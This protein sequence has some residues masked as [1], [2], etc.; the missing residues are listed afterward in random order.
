MIGYKREGWVTK[1]VKD[2]I[3]R[4]NLSEDHPWLAN[5]SPE[6]GEIDRDNSNIGDNRHHGAKKDL[7]DWLEKVS[8]TYHSPHK[9]RYGCAVFSLKRADIFGQLIV[10]SQNLM[11][12]NIGF[13]DGIYGGYQIQ[14]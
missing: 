5:I 6:T 13:I 3:I 12:S 9:F 8:L 10:I 2:D 4:N 14:I 1:K 7:K 11:H